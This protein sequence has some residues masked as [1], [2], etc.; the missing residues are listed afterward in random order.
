MRKKIFSYFKDK[1]NKILIIKNKKYSNSLYDWP[2]IRSPLKIMINF[3]VNVI[4]SFL[5]LPAKAW[6]Y[7]NSL[8]VKIGKDVAISPG[9]DMDFFYPELIS[10]G[11]GVII[12]K[13]VNILTHEFTHDHFRFGRVKIGTRAL[14]GA[15]STIRSGITIGK[16]SIVAMNS[17]VNKD[18]PAGEIWGGVPVRL[19]KT[20]EENRIEKNIEIKTKGFR[21]ST[22]HQPILS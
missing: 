7:R 8:G 17:F 14:V 21:N 15:Y 5:P 1:N 10:I 12:G 4:G 9:T 2:Q 6:L 13:K 11:S 3:F 20:L 16:N 18:I 22:Q 19:I